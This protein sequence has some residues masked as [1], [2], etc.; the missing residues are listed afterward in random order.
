MFWCICFNWVRGYLI[1][2]RTWVFSYFSALFQNFLNSIGSLEFFVNRSKS[3]FFFFIFKLSITYGSHTIFF[4]PIKN[5]QL[6][7][8]HLGKLRSCCFKMTYTACT[9]I[10]IPSP[11]GN[12]RD[13]FVIFL[14]WC[15]SLV[16]VAKWSFV[17]VVLEFGP[18]K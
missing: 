6:A 15:E 17:V 5:K 8:V 10:S 3:R 13:N 11:R 12:D 1:R 4:C 9:K 16:L 18:H 7:N 14:D 2:G